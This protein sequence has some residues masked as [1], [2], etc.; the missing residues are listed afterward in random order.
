MRKKWLLTAVFALL[1]ANLPLS[2]AQASVTASAS[3]LVTSVKS[4]KASSAPLGL[5]SLTLGQTASETL[6][7]VTVT[8]TNVGSSTASSSDFASLVVYKDNGNGNFDAGVD[9][10]AGTQ[11]VVNIGTPTVVNT[12]ANNAIDGGKFFVGLTT[13]STWSD[14]S[15]ADSIVANLV[16][17][18]VV[19]SANSPTLSELSTS[20]ITADT[21]AP[22]ITLAE[23][24]N[25]GGGSNKEAGDK[26][27][28]T[29]NETTNKFVVTVGNIA[30][31]LQLNNGHSFLDGSASLGGSSWSSD[32]KV[33]SIT[34]SAGTSL[35]SVAVGDTVTV[36]GSSIKDGSGNNASGVVTITGNFGGTVFN[37]PRG[38]HED[39]D[40][41]DDDDEDSRKNCAGG[42]KNGRLYK[43]R[44]SS[45][46]YLV[47]GCKFRAFRGASVFKAR[48]HKFMNITELDSLP[49]G[50]VV[51]TKPALPSEG[52]LI[53]G[54]KSKTVW[55]VTSNGKRRGFTREEIFRRLGFN[56]SSVE[57]ISQSDLDTMDEDNNIDDDKE[58]PSGA[59]IKC[60]NATVVY[61]VEH[62]KKHAF[63][64]ADTFNAKG[65][66]FKHILSVDCEKYSYSESTVIE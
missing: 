34:L 25:M 53:R 61:K 56:F 9:L 36:A 28:F 22:V 8:L 15:P 17:G 31:L 54:D 40:E 43:I 13:S 29:F 4:L 2:V 50:A 46:V 3:S 24:K 65:H 16:A 47:A 11:T 5:F 51:S 59:I 49:A 66:Q 63:T 33:L 60:E 26:L 18:S 58:H 37:T 6:A 41:E 48:G 38:N 32:G 30:S 52:T 19:T 62:G 21:T 44:G 39:D 14:S 35:P 10:V 42:V 27:E 12:S 23:A 20:A 55:F 64:S 45:T 7:S 1:V 57:I